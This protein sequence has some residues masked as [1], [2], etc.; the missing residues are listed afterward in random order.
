MLRTP[1]SAHT[2]NLGYCAFLHEYVELYCRKG[3]FLGF[4]A[5]AV[6]RLL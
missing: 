4:Y 1:T 3:S 5:R 2:P 6:V